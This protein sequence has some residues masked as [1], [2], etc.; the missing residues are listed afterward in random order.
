M[1]PDIDF[2][3]ASLWI[4]SSAFLP[5]T[6]GKGIYDM[7]TTPSLIA[8]L[9]PNPSTVAKTG[10]SVQLLGNLAAYALNCFAEEFPQQS[11]GMAEALGKFL[12][13]TRTS[14]ACCLYGTSEHPDTF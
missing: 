3:Q 6:I 4:L 2:L 14:G 10:K 8:C 9:T 12:E 11:S 13:S 1:I 7:G 5:K